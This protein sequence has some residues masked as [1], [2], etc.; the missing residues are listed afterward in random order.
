MQQATPPHRNITALILAGGA[1]SRMGGCAKALQ[2]FG[3][4]T[5]LETI[6]QRLQPQVAHIAIN[7]NQQLAEHA[8]F[9]YPVWPDQQSELLGPLAGVATGL[10]QCKTEFL[11]TVPCDSPF[12]P[13]DLVAKLYA[14]MQQAECDLV[15]VCSREADGSLQQHPV[16]CLLRPS[17]APH[18]HAYLSAGGRK[19]SHWWRDLRVALVEFDDAQ[20]FRNLNT[21]QELQAAQPIMINSSIHLPFDFSKQ[22]GYIPDNLPLS[23]AQ[24][25]LRQHC[26]RER[27]SETLALREALGRVLAADICANTPV[28]A[29]DNSAMDGF[30]LMSSD[31]ATNLVTDLA[32]DL[33][34]HGARRLQVIGSALAG[35]PFSG[36]MQAGQCLRIMTGAV[37]PAQCDTVIP[38]EN[39]VSSSEHEIVI[40]PN[41]VKPGANR[42][43][44]G[45]DLAQGALAIAKGTLLQPAQIGMLASLGYSEAPVYQ[46]LRV[47]FFST[48]DELRP[49]GS[50]LG[51]GMLYDSN[52]Y[53][54]H[55]LLS[56][57]GCVVSDLGIVEDQPAAIRAALEQAR[58][59]VDV[60]LT[61]GGMAGGDADFT[62]KMMQ[63]LGDVHF[64]QL[65]MRPGRPFA[66]GR[67]QDKNA[68]Q[69][70][71][72]GLP[73]N[74]VALMISFYMLVRPALLQMMGVQHSAL[75]ILQVAAKHAI[76]KA[77]GRHEFQRGIIH[78]DADGASRVSLTGAQG[79][80]MLSSMSH[81]NCLLALPPE[82]GDIAEGEFVPVILLDGLQ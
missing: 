30:A 68:A 62:R 73:G 52:R 48:G 8:R 37:V 28:P 21:R 36:T 75:P 61:S 72:F 29:H 12:L 6:L 54:L 34:N 35:H 43:K 23:V 41:S 20:A 14:T 58:G 15:S 40:A 7:A 76:R 38:H 81:A 60:V 46:R 39:V 82:M 63:E 5:L 2:A 44:R 24:D 16:F 18:L 64:W 13:L 22:A 66:F 4:S 9:G 56:K 69:T 45:E 11:L 32:T 47:G 65:K 42:R 67:M 50:E 17:L 74:P 51:T 25:I 57:L 77:P 26:P 59:Q 19:F 70:Y 49:L 71:L 80:A 55:A 10:A 3:T 27:A 33:A 78:S 31:L 1:A 53:S 79:S